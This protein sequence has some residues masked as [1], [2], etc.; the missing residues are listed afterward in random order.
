MKASL[1]TLIAVLFG[2]YAQAQDDLKVKYPK[3]YQAVFRTINN[4]PE[5]KEFLKSANASKPEVYVDGPTP[6]QHNYWWVKVGI[7]NFGMLRTTYQLFVDPKTLDV[8]YLDHYDNGEGLDFKLITLRQWRKWRITKAW[9][10]THRY[11][12]GKLILDNK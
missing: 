5:T 11:K 9:Q 2:L 4:L 7:G 3:T 6:S 8:Y 10:K 12:N 1:V